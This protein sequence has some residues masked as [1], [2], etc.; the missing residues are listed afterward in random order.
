MK[1]CWIQ[2]HETHVLIPLEVRFAN[3]K[4]EGEKKWL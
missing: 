4:E 2:V 1:G 3:D